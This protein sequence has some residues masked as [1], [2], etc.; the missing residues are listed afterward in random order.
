M[1]N[2][3][4]RFQ[5]QINFDKTK[6]IMKVRVKGCINAEKPERYIH[7]IKPITMWIDSTN[8]NSYGLSDKKKSLKVIDNTSFFMR[9]WKKMSYLVR[10]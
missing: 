2:E 4:D 5:N 1:N 6:K 10:P 7:K 9:S 8:L 3:K